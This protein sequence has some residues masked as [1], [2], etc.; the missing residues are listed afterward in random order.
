MSYTNVLIQVT[1]MARIDKDYP[2]CCA[3]ECCFFSGVEGTNG[4]YC[5]LFG[6]LSRCGPGSYI[7]WNQCKEN[8]KEVVSEIHKKELEKYRG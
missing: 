6:D 4:R 1:L 3:E 7:R 5:A 2:A 8:Q